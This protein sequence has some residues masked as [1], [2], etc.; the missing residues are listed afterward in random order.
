MNTST[1]DRDTIERMETDGVMIYAPVRSC[2]TCGFTHPETDCPRWPARED[3][4]DGTEAVTYA[5]PWPPE[6]RGNPGW[7]DRHVEGHMARL[8]HAGGQ[9]EGIVD[10]VSASG[11]V[12]DGV[13]VRWAQIREIRVTARTPDQIAPWPPP[14]MHYGY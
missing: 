3:R 5:P 11:M 2:R 1:E 10:E 4:T 8:T 14:G 9:Q 6:A 7:W 13:P 12:V